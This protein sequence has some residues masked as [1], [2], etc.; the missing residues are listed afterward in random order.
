MGGPQSTVEQPGSA[1]GPEVG[2][3]AMQGQARSWGVEEDRGQQGGEG[4]Q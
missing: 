4:V 3:A 2:V 1:P